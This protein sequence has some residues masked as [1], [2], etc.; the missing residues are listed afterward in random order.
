[1]ATWW[2][3]QVYPRLLDTVCGT[4]AVVD[5]RRRWLGHVAG[6]VL[7]IGIGS[8]LNIPMLPAAA[9]RALVGVEPSARLRARCQARA[10]AVAFPVEVL[11]GVGEALP[12][13][14][15]RFDTVLLTYTLCSVAA[16]ARVL[17]EARRVLRPGGRLVFLE[18]GLAPDPA[19]QRWQRRLT[20]GWRVVAGNC[21]LDR[22]IGRLVR[23]Q[24][25][26]REV[27]ARLVSRL[28]FA[29]S[30]VAT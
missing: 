5:E 28:S 3:A 11:A 7:E 29:T 9:V 14:A 27:D 12:L 30:G 15:A 4:R 2:D 24:F 6:E 26:L 21:H 16:P 22:D 18:H 20:P 19:T 10:R 25:E 13:D 1:M 17:A 8:G 23:D